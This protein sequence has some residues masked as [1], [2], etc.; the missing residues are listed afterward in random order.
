MT[1]SQ[2]QSNYVDDEKTFISAKKKSCQYKVSRIYNILY[3]VSLEHIPPPL[4][5]KKNKANHFPSTKL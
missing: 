4:K 3:E 1:T 5:R 2:D